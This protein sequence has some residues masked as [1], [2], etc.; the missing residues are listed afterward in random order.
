MTA[1]YTIT[2]NAG[3]YI[4][5]VQVDGTNVG[6]VAYYNSTAYYTF[7]PL[8]RPH[9]LCDLC[10]DRSHLLDYRCRQCERRAQSGRIGQ[11]HS[12]RNS[13]VQHGAERELSADFSGVGRGP[14]GNRNLVAC[15]DVT[16]N[17]T[18][19]AVFAPIPPPGAGTG[20]RG[21]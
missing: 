9:H 8:T 5:N 12:G 3:Y 14:L 1:L 13:V 16:A 21:D 7:D 15:S 19:S 20:L 6:P 18:V 17:H 10:L 4:Q 2:P 11:C